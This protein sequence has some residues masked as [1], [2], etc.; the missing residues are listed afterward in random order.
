[1]KP[2]SPI[3][4]RHRPN[5]YSREQYDTVFIRKAGHCELKKGQPFLTPPLFYH[6]DLRRFP[7]LFQ[8]RLDFLSGHLPES[9]KANNTQAKK[10]KGRGFLT[11]L[12]IFKATIH[13]YKNTR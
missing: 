9:Y 11:E 6:R 4:G 1:M 8:S 10:E 5:R 3:A 13:F 2:G 7:S 12:T